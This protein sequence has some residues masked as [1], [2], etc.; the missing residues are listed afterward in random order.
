MS[1]S[2]KHIR[3]NGLR[4]NGPRFVQFSNHFAVRS[5]KADAGAEVPDFTIC[6]FAGFDVYTGKSSV[7]RD[8]GGQR[9]RG[10]G[11]ESRVPQ[12]RQGFRSRRVCA[13]A[14]RGGREEAIEAAQASFSRS[15]SP[16]LAYAERLSCASA[17]RKT[18]VLLRGGG[19]VGFLIVIFM[20]FYVPETGVHSNAP[21]V[22]G[23]GSFE[24]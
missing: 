24:G 14:A 6:T 4:E 23:V 13:L 18:R 17:H 8:S 20:R 9:K 11:T 22:T 2:H 16:P 21:R 1:I 15:A 5:I 19:A 12:V 3:Y 10:G 7:S